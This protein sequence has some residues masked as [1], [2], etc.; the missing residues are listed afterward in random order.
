MKKLS[1][2]LIVLIMLFSFSIRRPMYTTS[3]NL[4]TST[5]ISSSISSD[6]SSCNESSSS[7]LTS[8][9]SST[10]EVKATHS[11]VPVVPKKP[12]LLGGVKFTGNGMP[13]HLY[14]IP[15]SPEKLD[16]DNEY[17]PIEISLDKFYHYS[18]L[19]SLMMNLGK[20]S[21]VNLYSIGKSVDDR[22]LYSIEIGTG[23]EKILYTAGV[24]AR[25]VANPLYILKFAANI[26]NEF[27]NNNEDIISLLKTRTICIIPVCNPDGYEAA[28][29]GNSVIKN[30]NLFICKYSDLELTTLKANASGVNL[31]RNF[32]TYAGCVLYY[33]LYSNLHV[34]RLPELESFAGYT[35]G[36]EPETQAMIRWYRNYLPKAKI[37]VD[38]HSQGRLIY[39]GKLHLSDALNS[40]CYSFA[41]LVKQYT[42]YSIVPLSNQIAGQGPDG[43]S[44][45][46]VDEFCSGFEYDTT[47]GRLVPPNSDIYSLVKKYNNIKYNIKAVTIE[48]LDQRIAESKNTAPQL[49]E[50]DN[51]K[52]NDMFLAI[53]N[54]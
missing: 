49:S 8:S 48:T 14:D 29:F 35:L 25:E 26:V 32:P 3:S 19:E 4:T 18:E 41:S 42:G 47:L 16:T 24:H 51:A 11:D 10:A 54:S 23:D 9:A 50:W 45:D 17:T 44:T 13:L 52:L 2:I 38:I 40:N 1:F 20:S 30:R 53:C 21:I 22:N 5:E 43:T 37:Y 34:T 7:S 31:N 46:F 33:K 6:V 12:E 15:Y 28:L 39:Q 36:S 27:Q